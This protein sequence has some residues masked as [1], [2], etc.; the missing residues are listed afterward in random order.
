MTEVYQKYIAKGYIVFPVLNYFFRCPTLLI[1]WAVLQFSTRK[2]WSIKKFGR[3]QNQIVVVVTLTQ[4][5]I[6][7]GQICRTRKTT[8]SSSRF[9][10]GLNVSRIRASLVL[11]ALKLNKTCFVPIFMVFIL[12]FV[13]INFKFLWNYQNSSTQVFGQTW[14][15]GMCKVCFFI[16]GSK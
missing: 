3:E 1:I 15:W 5:Q 8:Q 6:R 13:L 14:T 16:E 7:F 4:N 9:K 11:F 10:V 12:P 2:K